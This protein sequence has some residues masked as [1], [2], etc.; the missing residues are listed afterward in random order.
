VCAASDNI[1]AH[2]SS[3]IVLEN[4]I[5]RGIAF[6][7]IP[8]APTRLY[9]LKDL[10]MGTMLGCGCPLLGVSEPDHNLWTSGEDFCH[11]LSKIVVLSLFF[12]SEVKHEL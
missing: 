2:L 9:I 10:F 11:P 5:H 6:F 12:S 3:E 7:A 1:W 8:S 4:R